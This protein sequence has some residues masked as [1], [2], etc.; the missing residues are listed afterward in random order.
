MLGL[1]FPKLLTDTETLKMMFFS[2]DFIT[3]ERQT[4]SYVTLEKQ[5]KP[6]HAESANVNVFSRIS[7]LSLFQ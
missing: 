1:Y 3:E 7:L 5:M 6:T 4:E 2:R